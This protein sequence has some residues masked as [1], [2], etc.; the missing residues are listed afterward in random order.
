MGAL[1]EQKIDCHNHI[2]DPARYPYSS[3]TRYRP[4]GQEIADEHQLHAV[5][6]F[7][8]V[9]HCLVVQ[10]NSGYGP[11]NSCLLDAIARSHGRFK[12]VAIVGNDASLDELKDMQARGIVGVAFNATYHNTEYYL[13]TAALLRRL[14]ALGMCVQVQVEGDQLV[15]LMPLLVQSD[16][17][18][19]VDHC[20]R[21]ILANGLDQPGFAALAS[22]AQRGNAAIKLSG[23]YKF[24][25]EPFPHRDAWPFIRRL[26][27]WFGLE[28][29]VWGSDWPYLRAPLRVDYGPLLHLVDLLFPEEKDRRKLLWDTPR[30]LF[31][32]GQA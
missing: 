32:F 14:S 3:E 13:D 1:A 11:D 2:L 5:C 7:Y 28:R 20:G 22:L 23:L 17:A 4:A 19:V 27:D 18:V 8:G 9:N 21:P 26:V 10:P 16:V 15:Q 6:A 25:K 24:S 12:G 30:R 31:G 29:C